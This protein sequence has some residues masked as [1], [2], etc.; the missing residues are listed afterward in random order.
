MWSQLE[1]V[2]DVSELMFILTKP[3]A[4]VTISVYLR[5]QSTVYSI[6]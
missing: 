5:L 3:I 6:A 1:R 4:L 2:Y